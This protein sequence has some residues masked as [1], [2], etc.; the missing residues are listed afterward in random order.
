MQSQGSFASQ[1]PG[2]QDASTAAAAADDSPVMS[3]TSGPVDHLFWPAHDPAP[4]PGEL[5]SPYLQSQQR[6]T[7]AEAQMARPQEQRT[8]AG[9]GANQQQTHTLSNAKSTPVLMPSQP[10]GGRVRNMANK[11]DQAGAAD[12]RQQPPQLTVRTSE[13]RYRRPVARTPRS[14]TKDG[15]RK[16]QKSPAKDD[17][18]KLQ[19]KA[20]GQ[21]SPTKSAS[22]SF[23][24][25]TSFGSTSTVMSTKSQPHM[26][27]SPQK[28]ARMPYAGARPLFGEITSDG[29]W[30]GNFELGNYGPLPSFATTNRRSSDGGAALGHGRSQSHQDILQPA[31]TTA[32]SPPQSHGLSHKRSRSDMDAFNHPVAAPSMP[33]LYQNPQPPIYPTPPNSGS[34]NALLKE[35]SPT[36]RIP[37]RSVSAMSN[38]PA[39]RNRLSKSPTRRTQPNGKENVTPSSVPRARYHPAA[40]NSTNSGQS[41]SAKIVAP[42]PKTSPPLRSSRPRQPVSSATTSASRARAAERFQGQSSKDGRR[43][44]EQWLGKP[45]D[46]QKERSRR[47]I[48]ELGKIDFEARR[49]RIQKAISQNL[50][51]SRSHESLKSGQVQSRQ[52]SSELDARAGAPVEGE[53]LNSADERQAE[54]MDRETESMPGG[55]PTPGLSVDTFNV[56]SQQER[57]PEPRTANTAQTEFDLEESPVLGRPPIE[58]DR[59]AE[60]RASGLQMLTSATYGQ[61][62]PRVPTP[63]STEQEAPREEVQSPSVLENV[64]RMRQRSG[65][66][67]ESDYFDNSATGSP[68]DSPSDLEDR[69]GLAN[70][71]QSVQG[72]IKIML[73]DEPPNKTHQATRSW[74]QNVHDELRHAGTGTDD[75]QEVQ[76]LND[77]AYTANGITHSPTSD[78]HEA[79]VQV[80]P[81]KR[82]GRDDTIRQAD[83]AKSLA[84]D[85]NGEPSDPAVARALT[86]YQ[87]S[88]SL[89]QGM[90]EEMQRHMV[91]LQRMS[92]N[93]GSNG[94]MI[95]SLLDSI[96]DVQGQQSREPEEE[97][98]ETLPS[99][100]YDVPEV[101]PDTPPGWDYDAGTGTAVVFRNST[102]DGAPAEDEEDEEDFYVKIR[103]A[104]EEWERQQRGEYLRLE[105]EEADRPQPPPKDD[106]YTPRSS[107]GPNSATFA[108]DFSAGL[109]ISTSGQLDMPGMQTTDSPAEL[110]ASELPQSPTS[111]TGAPPQPSYAPPAPPPAAASASRMPFGMAEAPQLSA[112]HSER[113]SSEMSPRARKSVWAQSGSSRPSTD[114]QRP[115]GPPPVPGSVSMSSFTESGRKISLD[116]EGGA[117]NRAAKGTS[118]SPEQKRLQRRRNIIK[119]LIDTE[120][121]YHQDL[122]IIEDIY[123]ATA[124]ADLISP[125]DKKVL[126]GNCD[127]IEH[128]S[129][130]F[131]DDLRK[132]VTA[133]YVPAKSMR[134]MNKRGSY[135][136]TQSDATTQGSTPEGADDEKDKTTTI[137]Q[138]FLSNLQRMEVVYSCYLKN[139]DAANQRLSALRSTPT[140]KCWLEECHNNASDITSAWDL[141]SLL[142][143]P[144]QRIAKYPMLLQ[145]LLEVTPSAHPDREALSSAARDSVSMLTRINDAKKRADLVDQIVN[146]KRKD[147]DVRS[148][149]AKA[150]GRRT[151]KLKERVGIAEAFQDP[152]FE[153]LAHKLG[154]HFIRLQ[155]CLRDVQNYMNWTEKAME[156]VNNYAYALDLFTDVTVSSGSEQE[157]KWRKYGQAVREITSIAFQEHKAA[158]HKRVIDPMI[159][160]I[161]LHRGPQNAIANRKRRIVD[162]AK[163]KSVEKRGEKPDKKMIEAS[164]LYVAL[165]DQL[166]I[167]L[168]KLYSLTGSLVQ[169]C[170]N[171]FLEVQVSWHHTWERKL[172]PVLEAKDI[173]TSIHQIEPAFRADFDL[174]QN[175][176]VKLGICNGAVLAESANFLSPS[177][178]FDG[179]ETPSSKRP[180]T[181]D[182]SKRTM[183]VGSEASP[184]LRPS[185]AYQRSSSSYAATGGDN[186]AFAQ[187][188][189]FR[190]NSSMSNNGAPTSAPV[191]GMLA[192]QPWS[193][194][195]TPTSS[196]SLSRPATANQPSTQQPVLLPPRTSAEAPRSPRPASGATYYTAHPGPDDGRYSGAFSSAVPPETPDTTPSLP[197]TGANLKTM[198]VCA[199]LFEFSID[200]TRR[201]GG[202][203]YLTYVQ[204]EVFDV[205]AQKGE[206]W[207]AK[208]Q[209]DATGSLGWIWEQHFVIL[210]QD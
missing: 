75:V 143:K 134:W 193:N 178:T 27:F 171:C 21:R 84:Y 139:H 38:P 25:E 138:V 118:P 190:S 45:Y 99:T 151:E 192:N 175:E 149:I 168:P 57:E 74:S 104:D 90:M 5:R 204:G 64:M 144:T 105:H 210:S 128:F 76:Y 95:Q 55:W 32:L 72:S 4:S 181:L 131:Y 189:R 115:A 123:K 136:T 198:F 44:S 194:G 206:L 191:S 155:I 18:R 54:L 106:G 39:S 30:N 24:T 132:A 35:A 9:L 68:E 34:R 31:S 41:L 184:D 127:D 119:E 22:T 209:D 103:K 96:L 89:S 202:Y 66:Q 120:Y 46:P 130:H 7:S 117:Q 167:E 114:S 79:D 92:N 6:Q 100:T 88:G 12:G 188:A 141:D 142:V 77:R 156:Q 197:L 14:P 11:F 37:P 157:S 113:E 163:C 180:S 174:M 165:N 20:S 43:P 135:S 129:L 81:R 183:S 110:K 162:Y 28:Q 145:Q 101:T 80:T 196:F 40:L 199:S 1:W 140:V 29:R 47:K 87:E 164:E 160:C 48:P 26:A 137:G 50:E 182:S 208:N 61:P 62:P 177:T 169:G 109:R 91:D 2:G 58:E 116:T 173:P 42:L 60:K 133:V 86:E 112:T 49:E 78:G 187:D 150:F 161:E 10:G 166:K 207:L 176:L 203:P 186:L 121:T 63:I 122:K 53:G 170:L 71:L 83:F 158:V 3:A 69:W 82:P 159:A 148:G 98:Q 56:P 172:R 59:G 94:F 17:R 93:Q 51:E 195:N 52:V 124:V 33:N 126:F 201:E 108:P 102:E 125:E 16:L 15:V 147:S 107:L 8:G 70:G 67:A 185:G 153:Q 152:E 146:G 23:G 111:T 97:K 73:D 36:S 205:V 65:S 179:A 85:A 13:E 154:G 19:K 200:K